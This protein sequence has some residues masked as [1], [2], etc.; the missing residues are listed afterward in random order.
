M[1]GTALRRS[2]VSDPTGPLNW[3]LGRRLRES[4]PSQE[5][6]SGLRWGYSWAPYS[7][8]IL[9]GDPAQPDPVPAPRSRGHTNDKLCFLL[10]PDTPSLGPTLPHAGLSPPHA[11]LSPNSGNPLGVLPYSWFL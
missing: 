2:G 4:A 6:R 3:D 1:W 8:T 5:T 11:G 9:G 10:W 7:D